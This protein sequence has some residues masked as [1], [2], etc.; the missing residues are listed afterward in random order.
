[1]E[2]RRTKFTVTYACQCVEERSVPIG[3][4]TAMVIQRAR[5]DAS[6]QPCPV[7]KRNGQKRFGSDDREVWYHG[8]YPQ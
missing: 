5:K 1:M 6:Q 8:V 3:P 2:L 4:G 7:C